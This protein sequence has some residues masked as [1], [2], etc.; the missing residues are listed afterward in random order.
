M[1][2][3]ALHDAIDDWSLNTDRPFSSFGTNEIEHGT[4]EGLSSS[5]PDLETATLALAELH[6]RTRHA[7]RLAE[8]R[9]NSRLQ[10]INHE[11]IPWLLRVREN[12]QILML[13]YL[14]RLQ[15]L[16]YRRK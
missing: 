7:A 5:K 4:I 2:L 14:H 15:Y 13:A 3:S 16:H 6:H 1:S 10:E 11:P 12:L 9:I 8:Q